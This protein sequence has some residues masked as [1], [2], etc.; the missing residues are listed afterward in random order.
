MEGNDAVIVALSSSETD[1]LSRVQGYIYLSH[2]EGGAA[3]GSG[4]SGGGDTTASGPV[5]FKANLTNKVNLAATIF[6]TANDVMQIA[7]ADIDINS[8]SF[9]VDNSNASVSRI[10]IPEDGLYKVGVSMFFEQT[11][12]VRTSV[13]LRFLRDR[14]G[15]LSY[16]EVI[17][18]G[19]LRG[20]TNSF[21][22]I[23]AGIALMDL[24]TDDEIG[25][26]MIN[27]TGNSLNLVGSSSSIFL[28]QVTGG[29]AS[30]SG[31]AGQSEDAGG[32]ISSDY[33]DASGQKQIKLYRA[34]ANT[35]T[36]GEPAAPHDG[37]DFVT[38]FNNWYYSKDAAIEAI[39]D[40]VIVWEAA[41]GFSIASDST[42]DVYE[43][44]LAPELSIQYTDDVSNNNA[45]TFTEPLTGRYW[46]RLVM[47]DIQNGGIR[48]SPGLRTGTPRLSVM[49]SGTRTTQIILATFPLWTT[50]HSMR[51]SGVLPRRATPLF[52]GIAHKLWLLMLGTQIRLYG[53]CTGV[54]H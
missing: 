32:G 51:G 34:M 19:Y 20:Q 29:G 50:T 26:Q 17:G 11:A 47:H 7:D 25:V 46:Q 53:F 42:V 4:V 22:C 37:T 14:G 48:F 16:S 24:E 40:P 30:A 36:P 39:T 6:L 45:Y 28:T 9:T 3:G 33:V 31:E 2:D 41:G 21:Q 1:S 5:A 13:F 52:L 12:T 43:W 54:A 15:T 44:E 18:G 38:S 23:S 27:S 8:G 10:V 49:N 35:N